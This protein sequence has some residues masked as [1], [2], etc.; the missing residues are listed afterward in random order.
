MQKFFCRL[1][2]RSTEAGII[3]EDKA[4]WFIYGLEKR[5]TTTITAFL[6]LLIATTISDILT[7]LAYLGGFYFLRTRANGY[8]AKSF[9]G[10][11]CLSI[12]L[13]LTFLF[14]IFPVLT[15]W[16]AWSLNLLSFAIIFLF[17]PFNH[18][19]MHLDSHETAACRT[20]SRI[21]EVILSVITTIAYFLGVDH[22][23]R[24]LI[25]GNTM[26][27]LLLAVAKIK[28]GESCHEK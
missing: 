11:L 18:P 7:A 23:W 4:E 14:L 2:V 19:N 15:D 5:I 24:G 6:L 26:A 20:A 21:R 16:A 3:E 27:A 8:H 28:K 25:L 10:C 17:A 13:E 9:L 12:A 1:A 22:I